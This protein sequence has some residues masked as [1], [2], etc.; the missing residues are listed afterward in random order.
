MRLFAQTRTIDGHASCEVILEVEDSGSGMTDEVREKLFDPFFTTKGAGRGLGMSAVLGIVRAHR[1]RIEVRSSLGD[2][3]VVRVSFPAIEGQA[4]PRTEP[5]APEPRPAHATILVVDDEA[6]VRAAV[7]AILTH[8]GFTIVLASDG[9]EG[10]ALFDRHR[11]AIDLVLLDLTMPGL[12]GPETF[13]A[14]RARDAAVP[15]VLTS[16]FS[17]RHEAIIER[18]SAFLQKPY[19]ADELERTLAAVLTTREG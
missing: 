6:A 14:L 7:R 18:A 8:V 10:L 3:S 9:A 15:I 19:T 1:G 4:R 5:D 17:A 12:S 11:D 16:G 2:G 13:A